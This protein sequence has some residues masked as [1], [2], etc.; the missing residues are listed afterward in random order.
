MT[1]QSRETEQTRLLEKTHNGKTRAALF[2]ALGRCTSMYQTVTVE[3]LR[4]KSAGSSQ[5]G[6]G[7]AMTLRRLDAGR[8]L[9]AKAIGALRRALS[10]LQ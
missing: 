2:A 5:D 9:L 8:A 3:I 1:D 10:E 6:P 4:L 7:T